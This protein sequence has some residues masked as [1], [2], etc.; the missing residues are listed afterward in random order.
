MTQLTA[1]TANELLALFRSGEASPVE[2]TQAVL[3]RIARLNPLLNAFCRVDEAAAL[4]SARQSE[5]RWQAHRRSGVAVLPLDGVPMSIKDLILTQGWPTLRGS[6]TVNP[7]QNWDVD[8]PVTAR[9]RQAGAVLLGK[10][11]TRPESLIS[12]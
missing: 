1:F 9:L 2:V 8:A 5:S 6:R 11:T 4:N 12:K 7:Q 3:Q 10:T